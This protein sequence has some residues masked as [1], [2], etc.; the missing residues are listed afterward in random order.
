MHYLKTIQI[1]HLNSDQVL[2]KVLNKYVD[3]INVFSLKLAIELSEYMK[4]DNYDIKL[5]DN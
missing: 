1:I 2:T 5:V 3:F 4:T